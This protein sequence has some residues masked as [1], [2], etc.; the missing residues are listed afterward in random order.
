MFPMTSVHDALFKSVFGQSALAGAHLRRFL[1]ADLVDA[2]AWE[3]LERVPG[4]FTDDLLGERHTDLLFSVQWRGEGEGEAS[5]EPALFYI[6]AEHQSRPDAMMPMRLLRYMLRIWERHLVEHPNA[7]GV[8]AIF[9]VVV[10]HGPE[11]WS[12]ATRFSELVDI[13]SALRDLVAAHTPEFELVLQDIPRMPDRLLASETGDGVAR[14]LFKYVG[15]GEILQR[16]DALPEILVAFRSASLLTQAALIEYIV[17]TEPAL[18]RREFAEFFDRAVGS[19]AKE[20]AV[21]LAERIHQE[22][23]QEGRQEGVSEGQRLALLKLIALRFGAPTAAVKTRVMAAAD[24]DVDRWM[25]AL[26]DAETLEALL[27]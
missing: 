10:Y 25:A 16:L 24:E 2:L 15:R 8:P 6:L 22:G 7:R 4:S 18:E 20:L 5:R 27:N 1:N 17:R 26:L 13:P 3:T 23:R 19:E 14:I 11:P 21:T 12:A 9:P